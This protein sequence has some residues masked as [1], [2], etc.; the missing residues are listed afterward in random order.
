MAVRRHDLPAVSMRLHCDG[1]KSVNGN[2]AQIVHSLPGSKISMFLLSFSGE[3]SCYIMTKP[4][5]LSFASSFASC[6]QY[7]LAGGS[8]R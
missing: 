1:Y 6:R 3:S 8:S 4:I 2:G 7:S 5:V